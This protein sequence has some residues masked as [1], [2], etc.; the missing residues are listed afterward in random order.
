MNWLSGILGESNNGHAEKRQKEGLAHSS[1][2]TPEWKT[3]NSKDCPI[4]RE[5]SLGIPSGYLA[6]ELRLRSYGFGVVI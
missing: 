1:V 5:E 3:K 4:V 2:E 6:K